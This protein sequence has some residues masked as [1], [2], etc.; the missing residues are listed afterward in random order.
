MSILQLK[1][2][3]ER[4]NNFYLSIEASD[5]VSFQATITP[6][7]LEELEQ[8]VEDLQQA[9]TFLKESNIYDA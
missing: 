9:L 2:T 3:P 1:P 4:N 8:D 7:L 6:D 5:D